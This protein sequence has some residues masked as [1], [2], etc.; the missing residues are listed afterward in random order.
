MGLGTAMVL[1]LSACDRAAEPPPRAARPVQAVLVEATK[2]TQSIELSGEIQAEK[3]V[4]L[5]FRIAGRVAERSVNVGDQVK[6]G[7]VVARLEQ[8]IERNAV[9]AAK[10][11]LEAA[12]GQLATARN[13]FERQDQLMRQG[14]TTRP[15]FDAALKAQE[16]AEAA[17]ENAESQLE[18]AQERLSFT[19][20]VSTVAGVVT[21]RGAEPGEVVQAGQ[22][23]VQIARDDGRDAVFRVPAR[24]LETKTGDPLVT[25]ALAEARGVSTTGR[26]R[27]IAPQAD[28]V[29][30][31]FEVRVGLVDAPEA[32]RL[33]STVIGAVDTTSAVIMSIP[34]TAL[35]QQGTSAAV[36]V[37]DPAKSTVSLRPIDVLRFD[38]DKVIVSQGLGPGDTVV[39]A[40]IQALFPGQK[41]TLL[42]PAKR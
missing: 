24:L 37:V 25:V 21:M 9:A 33:G 8:T 30:R 12:R 40:G 14:F 41:V 39:S 6:P 36:W 2:T 3:T 18:L 22:S 11:A 17:L 32:M 1:A 19:D 27:E 29:T 16:T 28:P 35:T 13:A 7:Q 15:R 10:A 38:P 5:G 26:I 20:L 31:T 23:V 4:A 42:P 34:A